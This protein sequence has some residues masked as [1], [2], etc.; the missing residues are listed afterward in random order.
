MRCVS[1]VEL[2]DTTSGAPGDLVET[3]IGRVGPGWLFDRD[4]VI[5]AGGMHFEGNLAAEVRAIPF[6]AASP[7]RTWSLW[8]P[9]YAYREVA[10]G[11]GQWL[12]IGGLLMAEEK[13]IA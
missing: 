2:V 3:G 11:A 5:A 9:R 7:P 12:L 13:L 4:C 8:V 10:L 1:S 6:D